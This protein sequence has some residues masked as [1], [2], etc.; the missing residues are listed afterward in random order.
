MELEV[1]TVLVQLTFLGRP[2]INVCMISIDHN[3]IFSFYHIFE[4]Q[5]LERAFPIVQTCQSLCCLHTQN[6]D[7]D[8]GI[9]LTIVWPHKKINFDKNTRRYAQEIK[10]IMPYGIIIEQTDTKKQKY[11]LS[12]TTSSLLLR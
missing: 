7:V 4:L 10:S 12:E 2:A 1:S 5:M 6:M 11:N 9:I 8:E 3:I